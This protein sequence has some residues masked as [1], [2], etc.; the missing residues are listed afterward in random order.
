MKKVIFASVFVLGL[1]ACGGG[2]G[3]KATLVKACVDEGDNT[4]EECECIAS[5]F[6]EKLDPKL[7]DIMIEASKAEDEDAFMMSKM[8]ELGPD[9]MQSLMTT[10]MSLPAECGI[11]M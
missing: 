1:A 2:G 3:H 9:E 6:V 7:L 5:E 4:K 8:G 10:V 11:E